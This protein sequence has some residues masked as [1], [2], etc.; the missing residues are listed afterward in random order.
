V[1]GAA[2]DHAELTARAAWSI[3]AEPGD[4]VAGAVIE[5][6]GAPEALAWAVRAVEGTPR[7]ALED[8]RA[9]LRASP[10]GPATARPCPGTPVLTGSA[11]VAKG[12]SSAASSVPVVP[13]LA[14]RMPVS[15]NAV[16]PNAV[17]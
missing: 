16:S 8:L 12:D 6:L 9:R 14:V 15:P 17:V 3:V 13:M 5:A 11:T 10:A 7:A 4:A 2:P 1:T